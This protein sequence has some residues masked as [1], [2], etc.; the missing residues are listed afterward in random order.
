M[1]IGSSGKQEGSVSK[2]L[3]LFFL[4]AILSAVSADEKVSF[5]VWSQSA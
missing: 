2:I 5:N 3:S 4:L 1:C